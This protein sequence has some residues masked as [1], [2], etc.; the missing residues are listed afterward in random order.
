[1]DILV[2]LKR[3]SEWFMIFGGTFHLL[4]LVGTRE[5][6][7]DSHVYPQKGSHYSR[8]NLNVSSM[9]YKPKK[10]RAHV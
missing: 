2:E 9:P 7:Q 1:M 3:F 5:G 10:R 6:M 8:G 4:A